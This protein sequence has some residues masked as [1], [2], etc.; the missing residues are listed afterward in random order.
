MSTLELDN[1]GKPVLSSNQR[2]MLCKNFMHAE[3]VAPSPSAASSCRVAVAFF[4]ML[5]RASISK[6]SEDWF[7]TREVALPSFVSRVIHNNPSCHFDIFLHTWNESHRRMLN[8]ALQPR[9]AAYG[10]IPGRHISPALPSLGWAG[11]PAM[12]ASIEAVLELKRVRTQDHRWSL[13]LTFMCAHVTPRW[14]CKC[15]QDAE[16]A[17][18]VAYSWVMCTRLDTLWLSPFSFEMLN[19]HLFYLANNCDYQHSWDHSGSSLEG[20]CADL[21]QHVTTMPDFYFAASSSLMDRVFINLTRDI[22]HHCFTA[23][24]EQASNHVSRTYCNLL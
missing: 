2:R 18:G 23:T 24:Y 8:K 9:S 16:R 19:P 22:E 12:F 6:S 20:N 5:A 4:G 14:M 1:D 21:R 10:P 11:S 3:P 17:D 13:R 7:V 15:S